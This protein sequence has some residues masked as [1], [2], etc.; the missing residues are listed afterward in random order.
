MPF[1]YRITW[2]LLQPIVKIFFRLSVRGLEHLPKSGAVVIACNHASFLDPPLIALAMPRQIFFLARKTLFKNKLFGG[3]IK[4]YGAYPVSR[5]DARGMLTALRLLK[6]DKPLLLFPEGTRTL[7]GK[8]QPIKTGT[9]WLAVH[10]NCQILPIWI[11]G[12]YQS[13]P[14]GNKYPKPAKITV[15]IGTLINPKDIIGNNEDE[16]ILNTTKE[17]QN[18]MSH[19]EQ[20]MIDQRNEST[21]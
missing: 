8:L 9:A 17:L 11:E 4:Y 13:F 3:F 12:S 20:K 6:D 18:V 1:I 5:S 2:L 16:I 7:D 21:D 15:E 10:G 14:K 19:F